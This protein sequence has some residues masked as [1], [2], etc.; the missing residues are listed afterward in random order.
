LKDHLYIFGA[1]AF[2]TYGNLMFKH[3]MNLHGETPDGLALIPYF[4]KLVL[5][6]GW[7]VTCVL[8]A[9]LAAVCWMG[10]VSKFPL[11]YAFPFLSLNFAL[12]AGLSMLFMGEPVSGGKVLGVA[13]ICLGVIV[14]SRGF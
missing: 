13:L 12:V 14:V 8:S 7:L 10:A 4:F 2:T 9:F 11:S 3:R 5:T 6:S 1:I